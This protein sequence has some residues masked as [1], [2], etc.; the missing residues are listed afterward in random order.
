CVPLWCA[1]RYRAPF[2]SF[3]ETLWERACSRYQCIRK[4]TLT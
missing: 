2:C 4:S 1:C 3:R